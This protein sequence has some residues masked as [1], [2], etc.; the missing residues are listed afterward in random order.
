MVAQLNI[1]QG[2]K[3]VA[4][5]YHEEEEEREQFRS[6]FHQEHESKTPT[7]IPLQN[8]VFDTKQCLFNMLNQVLNTP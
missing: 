6:L 8:R 2:E 5:I 1:P 4:A 7:S 3:M